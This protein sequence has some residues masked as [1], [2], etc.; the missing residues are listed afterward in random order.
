MGRRAVGTGGSIQNQGSRRGRASIQDRLSL[1]PSPTEGNRP[2][3]SDRR[4]C[5]YVI[6]LDDAAIDDTRCRPSPSKSVLAT[7]ALL[8]PRG[9]CVY[10]GSSAKTPEA[11][12]VQ[13]LGGEK[14]FSRCVRKHARGL[15]PDLY[16]TQKPFDTREGAERGEQRLAAS[17]RRRGYIVFGG[18]P[19]SGILAT[20]SQ[21]PTP[22][23]AGSTADTQVIANTGSLLY[24]K[25]N[26]RVADKIGRLNRKTFPS[27][28]AA[29]QG[30]Y[31]PCS[32]C[33]P[34]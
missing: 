34:G 11:R 16:E 8:G 12:L 2:S 33:T 31:Q 7:V 20:S 10:V 29:R 23:T 13:H 24:H 28:V 14:Y 22:Q 6:Q 30:G 26:C 9:R 19:R 25:S 17:L 27:A 1:K 32:T 21:R 3:R 4:Y 5:V 15:R 18:Q